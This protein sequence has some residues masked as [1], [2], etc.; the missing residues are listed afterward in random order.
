M[1]KMIKPLSDNEMRE[2]VFN[3][4]NGRFEEIPRAYRILARRPEVMFKFVDFRDEIMRKGILNPKLKELIAV[5]VSEVNKCDAC[6]AIHK[7]KLG[8]VE[9]EFDEKTEVVLDF[10]E[11]VAINKGMMM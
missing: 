5:K 10:A 7:K 2:D 4:L 6:Y 11:K 9:F 8:D 3:F 1:V